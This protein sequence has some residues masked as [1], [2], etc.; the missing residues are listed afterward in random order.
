M[1]MLKAIPVLR[2]AALE[3]GYWVEGF[4]AIHKILE[5]NVEEKEIAE[6]ALNEILE[7][8]PNRDHLRESVRTVSPE[9]AKFIENWEAQHKC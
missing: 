4:L 5:E 3:H 7:A 2:E 1:G 6:A 8:T 9:A